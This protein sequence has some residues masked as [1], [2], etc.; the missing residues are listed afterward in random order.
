MPQT[1]DLGDSSV[2]VRHR[3]DPVNARMLTET[4]LIW[5]ALFVLG[6]WCTQRGPTGLA[7]GA[8]VAQGFWFQRLYVVGHES[9]HRKLVPGRANRTLNDALGQ[10]ALAP[11]LVPINVFRAIHKFHHGANRRDARS[12]ALDVYEVPAGAGAVRRLLPWALWY[13]GVFAGGWFLHSLISVLLFL[14]VPPSVARKV[15]PAFRGWTSGDQARAIASFSVGLGLHLGTTAI[16]GSETWWWCLGLP[17]AVFAWV[18]SFQLYAYHYRTTMGADVRFHV[19]SVRASR[20]TRWWLLD[21]PHHATHHRQ[22]NI[23]WYLL[24]TNERPLP[25]QHAKNQNVTTWIGAVVQQLL[26]PTI[27]ERKT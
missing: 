10:V 18:Y 5:L 22:P 16:W 11:L 8:A 13:T 26:G 23:P 2:D 7:A 1:I 21:L 24:R 4:L 6:V 9:A 15:S 25:E 14:F 27:V 19:R 20:L 17:L 3:L 12:A